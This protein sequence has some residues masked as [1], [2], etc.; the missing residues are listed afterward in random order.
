MAAL[1]LTCLEAD[2]DAATGVC[3][4]PFYSVQQT[5]LPEL[6]IAGAQEIGV[7]IA[8][9]WAICWVFRVLAKQIGNSQ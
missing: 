9:L 3:A 7:E 8:I 5:M 6:S 4:A 1:I 2:F